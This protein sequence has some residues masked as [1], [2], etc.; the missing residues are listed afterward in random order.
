MY[1]SQRYRWSMK[2]SLVVQASF[3]LAYC[4]A[5]VA[6]ILKMNRRHRAVRASEGLPQIPQNAV[7]RIS[8]LGR[9]ISL[10][11]ATVGS[12]AWMFALAI[13]ARDFLGAAI[14]VGMGTVLLAWGWWAIYKMGQMNMRRLYFQ[15]VAV[16]GIFTFVMV[17]W[18]L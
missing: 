9:F 1:L 5:L 4:V 16:L 6:M 8:P 2:T 7:M 11:G 3:W 17:N 14:V 12:L 18:R 15:F 13:P 10:G